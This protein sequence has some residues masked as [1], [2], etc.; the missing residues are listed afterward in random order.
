MVASSA[1]VSTAAIS[2]QTSAASAAL[3]GA[4]VDAAPGELDDPAFLLQNAQRV[5][6]G[7][8]A[9]IQRLGDFDLDQPLAAEMLTAQ[10]RRAERLGGR[11]RACD[12]PC[13][14]HRHTRMAYSSKHSFEH[15]LESIERDL[16]CIAR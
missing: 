16:D 1:S 6:D 11:F 12:P 9:D 8:L 2:A 13:D 5:A 4:H 3:K 15:F 14:A 10:N 7:V